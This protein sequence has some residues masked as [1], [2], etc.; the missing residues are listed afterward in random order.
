MYVLVRT[1]N[2]SSAEFQALP[3][4]R[5]AA[6][7]PAPLADRVAAAVERWGQDLGGRQSGWSSVG[8]VVGA[9]HPERARAGCAA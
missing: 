6:P 2:P 8:A 1:S 3:T 7:R 4:E 9:T 5:G